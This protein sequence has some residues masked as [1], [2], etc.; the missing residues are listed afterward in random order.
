MEV[1]YVNQ[2]E[3][4]SMN[5][6]KETESASPASCLAI[7]LTTIASESADSSGV[8][9][10]KSIENDL[11]HGNYISKS[12]KNVPEAEGPQRRRMGR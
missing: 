11:K 3:F 10:C 1:S 4:T 8:Y 9:I 7:P 12:D 6:E 5:A 2:K